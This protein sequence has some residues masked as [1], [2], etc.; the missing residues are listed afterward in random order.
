[1]SVQLVDSRLPRKVALDYLSHSEAFEYKKNFY[2]VLDSGQT[3]RTTP[4]VTLSGPDT[5][6]ICNMDRALKVEPV[7]IAV[8]V[9]E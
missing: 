9:T 1:M 3:K 5:G 8:E 6:C 4:C 7:R 2:M